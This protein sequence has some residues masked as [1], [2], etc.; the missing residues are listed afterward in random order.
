MTYKLFAV[1]AFVAMFCFEIPSVL[2]VDQPSSYDEPLLTMAEVFRTAHNAVL[3]E[4]YD[5]ENYDPRYT[6]VCFSSE[7][8]V[9]SVLFTGEDDE[10]VRSIRVEVVDGTGDISVEAGGWLW[11]EKD[12]LGK[13]RSRCEK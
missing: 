8:M 7:L 10:G 1:A 13:P 6:N 3:R 12:D 5:L 2:A 11:D 9:W 4:G